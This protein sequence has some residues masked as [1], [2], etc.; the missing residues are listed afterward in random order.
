MYGG[1]EHR[2]MVTERSAVVL[3]EDYRDD[4]SLELGLVLDTKKK[5]VEKLWVPIEEI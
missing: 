1:A 5:I 3:V 4:L 2:I